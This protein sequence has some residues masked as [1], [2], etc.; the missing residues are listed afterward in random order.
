[1]TLRIVNRIKIR[2]D[3]SDTLCITYFRLFTFAPGRCP[4]GSFA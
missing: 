4:Y 2:D 1:M 3:V